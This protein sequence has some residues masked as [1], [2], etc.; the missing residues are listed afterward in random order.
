MSEAEGRIGLADLIS[1]LRTELEEAQK[2]APAGSN[3]VVRDV[4]LEL[5]VTFT[6]EAGAKTGVKFWVY[7]AGIEGKLAS[8]SVQR[9]TLRLGPKEGTTIEVSRPDSRKPS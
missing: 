1:D 5:A 4:E 9:V 7:E 8:E 6:K 2:R 3:L